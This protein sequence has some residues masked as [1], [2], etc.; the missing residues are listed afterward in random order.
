MR[1]ALSIALGASVRVD[2]A[3]REERVDDAVDVD[4]AEAERH[5][6][7]QLEHP[8]HG[9]VAPVEHEAQAAV[10][11]AQPGQRQ[12]HLDHGPDEDRAGVDVELRVVAVRLRDAEDEAED[13][14]EVPED[15]RQ[16]RDREL[17]VAC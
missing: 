2:Q 1:N 17:L 16:R 10:A 7:H 3:R 6:E 15:R 5:R 13:D 12:Q 4:Q 9:R 14:R 8:P 11:A